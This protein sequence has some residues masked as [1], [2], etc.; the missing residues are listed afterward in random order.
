MKRILFYLLLV[1]QVA[2]IS[3]IAIQY[4]LID[5]YGKEVNILKEKS[6]PDTYYYPEDELYLDYEISDLS[7]EEWH[8]PDD[9]NTNE[10]VYVLLEADK[11]GVYHTVEAA[12]K[13]P[14]TKQNQVVLVG[15]Y[16][17]DISKSDNNRVNYGIEQV[18]EKEKYNKLDR[19]NQWV[20]T[21]KIAP[22]G[23]K[24]IKNIEEK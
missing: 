17:G 8:A 24:K 11:D 14:K 1:L 15:K 2:V 23:Q 16:Q 20:V 12:E 4:K 18:K 10:K 3:L 13:K 6:E 7:D 22:W 5:N 19:K 9:M 21:L